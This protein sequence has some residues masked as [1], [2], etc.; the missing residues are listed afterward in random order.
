MHLTFNDALRSFKCV[1]GISALSS[2]EVCA[3]FHLL[4]SQR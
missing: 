1:M 3:S 2:I 4:R